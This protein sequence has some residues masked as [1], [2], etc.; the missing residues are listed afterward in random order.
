M[1]PPD[2][3]DLM[4][5]Y[6]A[7][8]IDDVDRRAVEAWLATGDPEAVAALAEARASLGYLA[9]APVPATPSPGM[10][11]KL[12]SRLADAHQSVTSHR[13]VPERSAWRIAIAALLAVGVSGLTYVLTRSAMSGQQAVAISQLREQIDRQSRQ[14]D[15]QLVRIQV[16][17]TEIQKADQTLKLVSAPRLK[18]YEVT[19]SDAMPEAAGRLLWDADAGA[20]SFAATRLAPLT[21]R[22]VYELWFVTDPAGPVALGTFT[23]DDD[24]R[25]T[26]VGKAPDNL[27]GIQAVAVS[28]EPIGGA[29]G[30]V[31]T[32]PIVMLGAMK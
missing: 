31:P 17:S 3:R 9:L 20:L 4:L 28:I 22:Q 11:A 14:L 23:L 8:A 7:D 27:K 21:P 15:E 16:L 13:P 26:F 32:G 10:W 30:K 6:V 29:P 1:T 5:L 18:T 24:G 19:G 25:A 2:G 12:E